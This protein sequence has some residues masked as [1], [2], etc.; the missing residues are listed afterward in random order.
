[1]EEN[2]LNLQTFIVMLLFAGQCSGVRMVEL[3]IPDQVLLGERAVLQCLY[4]LEGEE[5]YSVK[6]YKQ[7][8]EFFR[9]IPGD[10]EQKIVTF[11]LPGIFVEK[12]NS[13]ANRVTLRNVNLGS[14]G[15][16]RCEVS[17]E[18]PLFN[19][20]SQ[21][22]RMQ[23]VA[24]PRAGPR[25]SGGRGGYSVGDLVHLNCTSDKSHPAANLTWKINNQ[26]VNGHLLHHYPVIKHESGLETS[27]LGLEFKVFQD[28]LIGDSMELDLKCTSSLT[29][30]ASSQNTE[31]RRQHLETARLVSSALRNTGV[32][33]L[34]PII[35][36]F[37][38]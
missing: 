36:F 18:A 32:F 21:S 35:L 25:I 30:T 9:Y 4:D 11:S 29:F 23:I 33:L 1:M 3:L 8:Q 20:V 2:A 19:T 6:W 27:I 14:T 16:Y 15:R 26:P 28:H 37:Y 22:K 10:R 7:G 24:M 5:L 17:A 38:F 12:M 13:N 34:L 31:L